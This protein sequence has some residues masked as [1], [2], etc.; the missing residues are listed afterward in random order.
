VSPFALEQR[1]QAVGRDLYDEA[2]T[3]RQVLVL[4][5][6]LAPG[7]SGAAVV[8][9]DGGL[10]GVAFAIAPDEPGTAYALDLDELAAL[11][12]S[13]RRAGVGTGPCLPS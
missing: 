4:A 9:T 12:D 6:D 1:V 5:A 7:D 2:D 13:P 11:L 3:Q 8:D 10:V